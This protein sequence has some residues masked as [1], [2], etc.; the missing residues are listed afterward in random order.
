MANSTLQGSLFPAEKGEFDSK[1]FESLIANSP[2]LLEWL[3]ISLRDAFAQLNT[4][5]CPMSKRVRSTNIH[6]FVFHFLANTLFRFP[7]LSG[8]VQIS[9]SSS[10]NQRNFF[11][12]GD[13]IFILKKQDASTNN[14]AITSLINHQL[15]SKHVITIEYNFGPLHDSLISLSLIYY[16]AKRQIYTKNISLSSAFNSSDD[17]G[18]VAEIVPTKPKLAKKQL[19]ENAVG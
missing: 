5:E 16:N 4:I 15:V 2:T 13:Y 12:F 10:G 6:E 18:E 14:T 1:H 9:T 7:D 3:K 19:G 11:I 8:K 17:F